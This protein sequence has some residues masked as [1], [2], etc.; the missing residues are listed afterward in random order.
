VNKGCAKIGGER[1]SELE[2]YKLDTNIL[3][4]GI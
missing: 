1:V 4:E 2:W 3:P